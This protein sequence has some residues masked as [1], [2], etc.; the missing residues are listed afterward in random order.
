MMFFRPIEVAKLGSKPLRKGLERF[1]S[2][3]EPSASELTYA[4]TMRRFGG[5]LSERLAE[6]LALRT[7]EPGEAV[8]AFRT[9][10]AVHDQ[11]AGLRSLVPADRGAS[12]V[13]R[14]I[15]MTNGPLLALLPPLTPETL[16]SG[17]FTA[18]HG[19]SYP[20]VVGEM[21][22][23]IATVAMVTA[24][25]RAGF[26]GFFGSAGL[27][28]KEIE[29]AIDAIRT[30]TPPG[31]PW[32]INL[33]HMP[34]HPDM[35]RALVELY[36]EKGVARVSASAFIR[37]SPHVVRLSAAGLTVA[38]DG[39]VER[40]THLFAKVS[41]PEVA[42]AFM[43]PPSADLLRELAAAGLIT[44]QQAELQS[45]LPL[46]EDVTVEADSG[47]HTDN[48]PLAVIYPAIDDVRRRIS[49]RHDYQRPIRLG[50]AGGLGT[51]ASVAAAFQLGADYVLTGSINQA[52]VESG[53]S[54]AGRELLAACGIADVAMAP[55][56]DMFERGGRVQVL[57]RGTTFHVKARRLYDLYRRYDD[58]D[59]VP[60]SD[61][62]WLESEIFIGGSNAVWRE[63]RRYFEK[64]NPDVAA[65]AKT[66]ARLRMALMFRRYLFDGAHWAREGERAR[67]DD[68]QI[69][70]GPAMGAFNEW[71]R[72]S[73]LEPLSNRSV[74]KIGIHL[75]EGACR[76]LRIQQLQQCGVTVPDA[77]RHPPPS[78]VEV[79]TET[80]G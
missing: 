48:R 2:N 40:R 28:P 66:D 54:E 55:A 19:C 80:L 43:E 47:G 62:Q 75:L 15:D 34:N 38:P 60:D 36:L 21:A 13:Y 7:V 77:V 71:V 8:E 53:L 64:R 14:L 3:A 56:A 69:W 50:A 16:G 33:I 22:R 37:P 29:A 78:D 45:R 11:G 70:C 10:I 44:A 9:A 61:R 4:H 72:G 59:S 18:A 58:L 67:R 42:R 39:A 51:P 25:A 30:G 41:R 6:R 63:T 79:A 5:A 49:E 24:A 20:Y 73:S 46:A 12:A 1:F 52:A 23:G 57:K 27:D 65:R 32:G 74:E 76:C 17:A 31:C 26:L 35:E 68:F